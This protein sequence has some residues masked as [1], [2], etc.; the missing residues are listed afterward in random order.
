MSLADGIEAHQILSATNVR[1]LDVSFEAAGDDGTAV[2]TAIESSKRGATVVLI[3]IP[4]K[5]ETRFSASAA[6]HRGL[7]IKL[8]RRMKNTYPTAIRLVAAGQINL[9]PLITHTY[10]V[11]QLE[12]AFETAA[13]RTGIKVL[14]NFE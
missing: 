8:S 11:E 1:G 4:E 10:P 7:T 13:N 9:E 12:Q 5:D 14:I 3:G 6:R 2:E